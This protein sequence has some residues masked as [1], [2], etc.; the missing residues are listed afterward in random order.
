MSDQKKDKRKCK[1]KDLTKYS[2]A[3]NLPIFLLNNQQSSSW[4]LNLKTA[5]ALG[6]TFPAVAYPQRRRDDRN[7]TPHRFTPPWSV[8]EQPACFVVKGQRRRVR[9]IVIANVDQCACG[10]IKSPA[11]ERGLI[12]SDAR[13]QRKSKAKGFLPGGALGPL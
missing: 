5:N 7:V 2:K 12:E 11:I 10:L 4:V 3:Q 6:L 9:K 8:E 1:L 13:V